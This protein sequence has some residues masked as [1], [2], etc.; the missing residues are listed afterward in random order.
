MKQPIR[1]TRRGENLKELAGAICAFIILPLSI[2]FIGIMG[3]L[4]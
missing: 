4:R 3:G 2:A 1:L